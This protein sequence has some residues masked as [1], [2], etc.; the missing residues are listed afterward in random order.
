MIVMEPDKEV[1]DRPW[2]RGEESGSDEKC[3]DRRQNPLHLG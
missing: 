3:K 1:F 2:N